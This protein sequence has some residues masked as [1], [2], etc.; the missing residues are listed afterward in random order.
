MKLIDVDEARSRAGFDSLTCEKVLRKVATSLVKNS[1]D[2]ETSI[3]VEFKKFQLQK[4]ALREAMDEI[5]E[6]GYAVDFT[7]KNGIVKLHISWFFDADKDKKLIF[8]DP[9]A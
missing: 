4:W 6:Q 7:D 2:E 9:Y 1:D 3:S 8:N 5:E